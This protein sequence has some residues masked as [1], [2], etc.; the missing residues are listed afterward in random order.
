MSNRVALYKLNK[1]IS[2][3]IQPSDFDNLIKHTG[4]NAAQLR[5][6]LIDQYPEIY[7]PEIAPIRFNEEIITIVSNNNNNLIKVV[8]F[9]PMEKTHDKV[10]KVQNYLV[11]PDFV[12]FDTIVNEQRFTNTGVIFE[13]AA[14]FGLT[15]AALINSNNYTNK[16]EQEVRFSTEHFCRG[17]QLIVS[18]NGLV[19]FG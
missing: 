17:N 15:I 1:A 18:S 12:R 4:L 3:G 19:P 7:N 13:Q 10:E 6:V 5:P 9:V 14:I 8:E 16:T 11:D 2:N